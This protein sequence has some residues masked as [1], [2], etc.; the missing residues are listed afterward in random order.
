MAARAVVP[1]CYRRFFPDRLKSHASHDVVLMCVPCHRLA[2]QRS[3]LE[4]DA[5]AESVGIPRTC[6]TKE[7]VRWWG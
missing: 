3:E 4:H 7:N 2:E 6:C 1:L 5:I